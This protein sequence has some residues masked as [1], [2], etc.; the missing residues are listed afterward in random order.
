MSSEGDGEPAGNVGLASPRGHK[1]TARA[2]AG[3]RGR[4]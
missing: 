3:T 4:K 2:V 1:V